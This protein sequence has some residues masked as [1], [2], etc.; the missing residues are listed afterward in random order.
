MHKTITVLE[1]A[2]Y[3]LEHSDTR[4]VSI[5]FHSDLCDFF[6]KIYITLFLMLGAFYQL[7][8]F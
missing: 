7:R 2:N 8:S 5:R 1:N 6:H 3:D 4:N